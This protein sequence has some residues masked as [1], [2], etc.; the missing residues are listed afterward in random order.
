MMSAAM[1]GA[2]AFQKGLGAIH[3]LSHPIGAIYHTHHGT[4]NAVVMQEVMRFNRSDNEDRLI[5]AARYLGIEDGFNGFYDFVGSLITHLNIPKNLTELGLCDLSDA[6]IERI[7]LAAL[8]D[9][10]AGGNPREMTISNT[11]ALLESCF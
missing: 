9:P 1:M 4:T 11:W 8:T 7:V 6:D 10:S 5:T 2:T 3:A